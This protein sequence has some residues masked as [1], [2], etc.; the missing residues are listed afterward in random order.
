M[1]VSNDDRHEHSD[2]GPS[3]NSGP[4]VFLILTVFVAILAAIF[5]FQN[6]N[7]TKINLLFWDFNSRVWVAIAISIGL[8][9]L[10]DRLILSWWRR[11][12]NR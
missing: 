3:G 8:G 12:R 11:A 5:V 9:V 1:L 4:S 7:R 10:L 2:I 6:S